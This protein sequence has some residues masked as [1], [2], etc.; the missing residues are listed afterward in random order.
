VRFWNRRQKER[1]QSRAATTTT[2]EASVSEYEDVEDAIDEESSLG[3]NEQQQQQQHFEDKP[4]T[5]IE[6]LEED[7]G[8]V[9]DEPETEVHL[10]E[11]VQVTSEN[12]AALVIE[13][14]TSPNAVT[15]QLT[16]NNHRLE[17]EKIT[18][19]SSDNNKVSPTV[20]DMTNGYLFF[21]MLTG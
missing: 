8:D 2:T 19:K 15:S 9:E 6:R 14:T 1:L 10:E 5:D 4:E 20:S 12:I 17:G 3:D 11:S 18:R 13:P 7:E 21:R 16:I